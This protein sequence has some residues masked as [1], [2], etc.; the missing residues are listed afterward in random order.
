MVSRYLN[1]EEMKLI[2]EAGYGENGLR[3]TLEELKT[4]DPT[5]MTIEDISKYVDAITYAK[6]IRQ[7]AEFFLPQLQPIPEGKTV[8]I[9]TTGLGN[10]AYIALHFKD[11]RVKNIAMALFQQLTR[12]LI[13]DSPSK[14]IEISS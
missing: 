5:C 12:A 2:R 10:L 1:E 7:D 11:E 4:T 14:E 8:S 9:T 13:I 6:T 3:Y